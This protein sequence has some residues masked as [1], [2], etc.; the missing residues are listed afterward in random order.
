MFFLLLLYLFN[1]DAI[2]GQNIIDY[3]DESHTISISQDL[4]VFEDTDSKY[5][6]EEIIKGKVLFSKT[7]NE[8]PSYSF[9]KSTV[10]CRFSLKNTTSETC[11]LEVSPPILN[12]VTLYQIYDNEIDSLKL[13]SFHTNKN[14]LK[15]N[16]YIFKLDDKAKYFLLKT[17]SKTRLFIKARVGTFDAFITKTR[18]V[19]S[20]QAIYAGLLIMIFIYNLF[21]FYTN[22]EKVYLFYLLHL[23]NLIFYFLYIN[24]YGIEFIWEDSPSINSHYITIL[25]LGYILSMFFVI[26]FLDAKKKFP[27]LHKVLWG[28]VIVLLANSII[29]LFISSHFAGKLLNYIGII[30]VSLIILGAIKLAR[31]GYKHART[32][33][34]A[35]LFYLL[36]IIIQIMQSLNLIPTNE[37]TSNSIQIGS[38]F[39]IILLSIAIANKINFY[40]ERKLKAIE[41]EK[42]LLQEK[43]TLK[44]SQKENLEELFQEQTELLYAKNKELKEQNKKIKLKHQEITEQNKKIT[45]YHDLLEAKN[46]IITSQHEDLK[47]HKENLEQL[48]DER[49]SELKEATIKAENADQ[50]KTAFLKDF[51]HEIRTPMNAI[52]GF[53]S[54]LMDIETD[55]E[56]HNYYVEIINNHTDNLLDLIEN[57][58]DLSKIQNNTLSLKKVKFDPDKMFSVLLEK[59]RLKLK[60]EKKSFIELRYIPTA[61]KNIRLFLDYNRFWKIVYQLIDNS[62]KYTEAGY[63][64]FG[65]K[66]IGQTNNI[67]VFVIDTGVGIR[68]EKLTFVF[69]CFRKIDEQNK[70]QPG[71]GIGLSLV[72]G[73]TTLMKGEIAIETVSAADTKDKQTG[74]TITIT[75]PDAIA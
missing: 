25:S 48:I 40:K 67:E 74:T 2:Q 60:R 34:Y 15:S 36:G 62:I 69:E 50:L 46:K 41:N 71:V 73:L 11:Y 23:T 29:D 5:N 8:I 4:E 12:E 16:N 14:S 57:I 35:W 52:S 39:E 64:E 45:E 53:S 22:R 1:W 37:I 13:G 6:V 66:Q 43:K 75:I 58:V 30:A 68:K 32:F 38:A 72:K 28:L 49:T 3:N 9:T 27:V 63:I 70:L 19:D 26:N 31:K 17:R 44:S 54:L 56:S 51:S 7:K 20:I 24:G 21:L 61:S 65:F 47:L 18:A 33:L 55:D 42:N 10:W 59:Q